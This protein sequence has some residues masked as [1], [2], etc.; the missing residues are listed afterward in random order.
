MGAGLSGAWTTVPSRRL[1][2]SAR[3][4][5]LVVVV[6]A[7]AALPRAGDARAAL[8]RLG[9]V[10]VR[11]GLLALLVGSGGNGVHGQTVAEEGAVR[12][13]LRHERD[14]IL[15]GLQIAPSSTGAACGSSR[16]A[17]PPPRSRLSFL[18]IANAKEGAQMGSDARK[19]R[20]RCGAAHRWRAEPPPARYPPPPTTKFSERTGLE[21]VA[22]ARRANFAER[23]EDP[24]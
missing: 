8:E 13:V 20:S 6:G 11:D 23:P 16:R 3:G 18:P 1:T 7:V 4:C 24:A 21:Q 9:L 22:R 17:T 15:V 2:G 10:L 19:V 12:A 5:R 14:V